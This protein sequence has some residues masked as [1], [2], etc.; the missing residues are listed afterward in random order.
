MGKINPCG[1]D[2]VCGVVNGTGFIKHRVIIYVHANAGFADVI[3]S[4]RW[5]GNLK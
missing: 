2:V 1:A 3:G 4:T 5:R